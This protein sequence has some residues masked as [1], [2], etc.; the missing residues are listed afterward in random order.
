MLIGIEVL[1]IFFVY[2]LNENVSYLH[3]KNTLKM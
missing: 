2:Y 3:C 1:Y